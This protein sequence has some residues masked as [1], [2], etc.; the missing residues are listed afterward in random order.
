MERAWS[1]RTHEHVKEACENGSAMIDK[2][3]K[4]SA[5]VYSVA[6]A[7][8]AY[9]GHVPLT[10]YG[11]HEGVP[12]RLY[13]VPHA[14]ALVFFKSVKA[15]I[16]LGVEQGQGFVIARL[17]G[18]T[19][20]KW[21]APAFVRITGVEF[22]LVAGVDRAETLVGVMSDRALEA[23]IESQAKFNMSSNWNFDI[24]P[25]EDDK[26]GGN[27]PTWIFN[28]D[29]TSVSVSRGIMADVAIQ[30]T[31]ISFDNMWNEKC[32]GTSRAADI[33]RGGV[34]APPELHVMTDKLLSCCSPQ[35]AGLRPSMFAPGGAMDTGA[36]THTTTTTTSA[37]AMPLGAGVQAPQSPTPAAAR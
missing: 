19:S 17:G 16:L 4:L 37:T 13:F 27:H 34:E 35:L 22:G 5:Q 25:L 18:P 9:A 3:A 33:L 26:T 1:T 24:T 10:E 21:S 8:G 15:G 14:K 36:A 20:N 30:G 11:T 28:N 23:M 12:N 31:R 6:H 32:Y 7:F 2:L 29:F